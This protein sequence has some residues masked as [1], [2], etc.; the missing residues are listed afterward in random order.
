MQNLACNQDPASVLYPRPGIMTNY[1]NEPQTD[2][3]A[4]KRTITTEKNNA[5]DA[6]MATK[7]T[8]KRRMDRDVDDDDSGLS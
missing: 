2:Q 6:Q 3:N 4:P 7:M 8:D 5:E 1:H